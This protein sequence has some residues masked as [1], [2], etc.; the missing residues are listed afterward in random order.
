MSETGPALENIL[1]QMARPKQS[2]SPGSISRHVA[3]SALF[4]E[5][6]RHG[7]TA[8]V[9]W[10]ATDVT[11]AARHDKCSGASS[12]HIHNTHTEHTAPTHRVMSPSPLRSTAC[13]S[14]L[15]YLAHSNGSVVSSTKF[16]ISDTLM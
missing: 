13:T 3:N 4:V 7:A 10:E 14:S 5:H 11:W 1:G 8:H 16:R 2:Y 6:A 15:P 9:R 12:T